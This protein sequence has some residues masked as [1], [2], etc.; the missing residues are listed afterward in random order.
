VRVR[1]S[2]RRPQE[3]R[4]TAFTLLEVFTVVVIIAILAALLLPV[5]SSLRSR[6]QRVQCTANLRSLYLAANVYVQQNGS[7]PQIT[8]SD[9]DTA[10]QDY[11][12]AWIAALAR[13]HRLPIVSRDAHFDSVKNVERRAWR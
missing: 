9:S 2:R 3:R 10:E 7:W 6:A 4:Q 12:N 1:A 11:A 5:F 8:I 13:Q